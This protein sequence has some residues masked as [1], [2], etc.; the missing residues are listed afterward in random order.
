MEHVSLD[1]RLTG[2]P[3]F[4]LSSTLAEEDLVPSQSSSVVNLLL[5]ALE[6]N[7]QSLLDWCL[8][9]TVEKAIPTSIASLSTARAEQL[10]AELGNRFLTFHQSAGVVLAWLQ[11]LLS[12]HKSALSPTSVQSIAQKL[13]IRT[14][15]FR[16]LAKI[17]AKLHFVTE[18]GETKEGVKVLTD[19]AVTYTEDPAEE[20]MQ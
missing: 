15:K 8:E 17:R 20:D 11:P 19:R 3:A 12:I 2:L 1:G 9:R 10:L 16:Q 6:S 4:S 18:P 14:E 13:Q 5:Q 7:D